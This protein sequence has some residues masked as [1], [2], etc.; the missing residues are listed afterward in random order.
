MATAAVLYLLNSTDDDP[1]RRI[2]ITPRAYDGP[3]GVQRTTDLTFYGNGA[4]NWGERFNENF[5]HLLENFAVAEGPDGED[6][7]PNTL[8]LPPRPKTETD[9]GGELGLGVNNPI[10]GQLWYNKS[11]GLMYVY[12]GVQYAGGTG[13]LMW[14]PT[15]NVL[16]VS[17]DAERTFYFGGG[18]RNGDI[19]FNQTSGVLEIFYNGSWVST[20][21]FVKLDG[22]N[23]P[24]TGYLTLVG[25]PTQNN[26]AATK[27]YVDLAVSGGVGTLNLTSLSDVT[28]TGPTTGQYLRKS[29]VD[30]VNSSLLWSDMQAA[31]GITVSTTQ[32]N[33]LVGVTS[34]IQTQLN[35][36]VNDTGD[37]MTGT[38]TMS[39]GATHVVLP[40]APSLGTHA[41][42]KAYV[43]GL[44]AD[45]GVI[46]SVSGNNGYINLKVTISGTPRIITIQWGE[47][48]LTSVSALSTT[49]VTYH[50]QFTSLGAAVDPFQVIVAARGFSGSYTKQTHQISVKD[51]TITSTQFVA[52]A[53]RDDSVDQDFKLCYI[54]IGYGD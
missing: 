22:S 26:H 29:A 38:L 43:D 53:T 54:A 48:V 42:N 11:R 27:Q 16:T 6:G 45:A 8:G 7:T 17:N 13:T 4:P 49:T 3:G 19:V 23:T 25:I 37:T 9:L 41:A 31:N 33:Y 47:S 30:W 10:E 28:I 36:K 12:T 5:Y 1:D 21:N 39:G 15:S 32:L 2:V 35:G 20:A 50:K 52:Y 14:K 51:D 44:L 18:E 40:N 24:M 46:A 34:G